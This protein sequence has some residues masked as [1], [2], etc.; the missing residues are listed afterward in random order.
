MCPTLIGLREE[1]V[2]VSGVRASCVA[3]LALQCAWLGVLQGCSWA[4]VHVRRRLHGMRRVRG[5]HVGAGDA[6]FAAVVVALVLTFAL[7]LLHAL[8]ACC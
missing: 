8:L 7:S 3:A 5:R 1:V 4:G 2:D 6:C